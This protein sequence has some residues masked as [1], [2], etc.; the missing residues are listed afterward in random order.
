MTAALIKLLNSRFIWLFIALAAIFLVLG[1][2][3]LT[4]WLDLHPCHLC[5]F[6]RILFMLIAMF[7]LVAFFAAGLAGRVAGYANLPISG[8]GVGVAAYQTWL[9]AQPPGSISCVAGEPSLIERVV[10]WLGQLSPELFLATGFCEESELNILGLSLAHWSL[11]SFSVF[12][13]AAFWAL[14]QKTA[15]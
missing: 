14:F 8:L 5:I 1:S 11:L 7:G 4:V 6:Q 10:E 3:V 9:Q 2:L 15:K 12:L 13:V